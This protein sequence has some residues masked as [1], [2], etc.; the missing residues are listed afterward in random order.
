MGQIRD[1]LHADVSVPDV[2]LE[3]GADAV[4]SGEELI[5]SFEKMGFVVVQAR[6]EYDLIMKYIGKNNIPTWTRSDEKAGTVTIHKR[7]WGSIEG[8]FLPL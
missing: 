4:R 6:E 5:T 7:I 3:G 8:L 1:A 2:D